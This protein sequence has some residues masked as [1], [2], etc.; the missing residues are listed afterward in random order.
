MRY[1][2][3][4]KALVKKF[5]IMVR[6]YFGKLSVD[7]RVLQPVV[8]FQSGKVG[9]S[10]VQASLQ[11]KYEDLWVT[12]PVYHA[13]IL[14]NIDARMEFVRQNRAVP[15][16]TIKMLAN[17][18]KLRQKID[19]DLNQVW[20]VINL[21][22]DPVAIKVSALFQ[23]LHEYIPGWK[24]RFQS[25]QL[26]LD[27]LEYNLLNKHEFGT[28]GFESWYD[29]QIKPMWGIDIFASPFAREDGYQIYH[30]GRTNLI[31][32]RLEDLNRVAE[33]AFEDFLG[34][35]G[36][37][38]INTNLG[39]RKRYAEL[40]EQFKQRPLPANYVDAIYA[41]RFAR[42][43]YTDSEIEQFRQ[44]WTKSAKAEE[45]SNIPNDEAGVDSRLL[46]PIVIFQPGKVG[47]MSVMAHLKNKFKNMGLS[48]GVYH[49]RRLEKINEQIE[50]VRRAKNV[51]SETINKLLESKELRNQ[52]DSQ[53]EQSWNVLT[54]VREPVAQ[55]VSALFQVMHEYIPNWREKM[56]KGQ[57]TLIELQNM[58]FEKEEFDVQ[59]LDNW[60]DE[61]MKPV[62]G[63]DVY[64]LP[65]DCDLGYHIYRPN[66][67][68][69]LLIV[70]LEDLDHVAK[71][72]FFEFIGIKEFSVVHTNT[73]QE[74][75]YRE[76]YN[77]FKA[78]PLPSKFVD[79]AYNTRYA[80]HFYSEE[81]LQAFRKKWLL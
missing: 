53:P 19:S 81:E 24:E 57:L 58:L 45:N 49:T 78:L 65:F 62:W 52:I 80:R 42:H 59:R 76:L 6:S 25:G 30:Q 16:A 22:R 38:I 74:K 67:K 40:Y 43:F 17:S 34:I 2:L 44:K 66:P 41:S 3:K 32:I 35:K 73:S 23:T 27:D 4:I 47:S 31:V 18:R 68:I 60:F 56:E 21:V 8:I 10:S 11:R 46:I 12:T 77:Q 29:S 7:P 14:E 36:L 64:Q 71:Q 33:R 70:R 28:G 55:R 5:I 79:T 26:T 69:S 51:S 9:S 39:E 72:A 61:Q 37:N 63:L 54:L 50:F 15:T 13:H 75:P 1:F 20:N 48:T